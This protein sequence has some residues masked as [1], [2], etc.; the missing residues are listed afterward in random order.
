MNVSTEMQV[1]LSLPHGRAVE[2]TKAALKEEGFGVLSEIDVQRAM[3]E[4]LGVEFEPYVILGACNP[5]LAHRA[6]QID[7]EIGKRLPCNVIVYEQGG[8]SIVSAMDPEVA[9]GGM[10]VGPELKAVAKE[11]RGRLLRVIQRLGGSAT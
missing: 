4:K 7:R 2:Q 10:D 9:L 8:R 3:K 6:L 5:P 11:A 1:Q